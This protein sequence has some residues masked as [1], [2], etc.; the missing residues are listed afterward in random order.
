MYNKHLAM[1]TYTLLAGLLLA[2]RGS[3]AIVQ[4]RA[5]SNHGWQ[6]RSLAPRDGT[7]KLHI[8]LR[9]EDDG[10]AI[11]RQ[12][13]LA[14]DPNSP[15]F[16]QHISANQAVQLSKPATESVRNVEAWLGEH[17]LLKEASLLGGIFEID[18]SLQLAEKLLNTT[19]FT[20]SDGVH[21][22]NRAEQCSL[23]ESVAR[24]LD[25]V[26][27]TTSFPQAVYA[28]HAEHVLRLAKESERLSER[29]VSSN[30]DCNG[31]D[32]LAT[33]TCIR[34]TYDTNFDGLNYTA[35][36]NR[37]SFA[38]YATEGASFNPR[39]LQQ[40]MQKYNPP[41]AQANAS[42]RVVGPGDP[43][44]SNGIGPKFETS[45]TTSAFLGLAY[46]E[47]Q[48]AILYNYGGVF[49]PK[50]GAT[51]D[52]FVMFLQQLISNETVPSVI[53]ISESA[54]ENLLDPDYARR[55]CNMMAQVGARGVSLLFSAGN[56]GPNG[57]D[58][59]GEHK[60]IFEPKFP[61]SCPWVT[62]VG[63]TTNLADEEAAT[64]QTI[65]LVSQLGFTSTGGGFS[66]V[67]ARPSYQSQQVQS[68]INKHI[69]ESYQTASGFNS[70]GRGYPDISA[71]ST[72]FPTFVDGFEVPTGG[73][74]A[75]TPTWGAVIALL[76][77]YEA[78]HGRPSLGFLNPWLYSLDGTA[79]KD[80]V[81][82]GNNAGECLGLTGGCKIGQ[83]LGF[84]VT[85]GW[86]PATGLGSPK[87]R[88]LVKISEAGRLAKRSCLASLAVALV[89][90][91]I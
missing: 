46:P 61:A 58:P 25:F 27:P 22:I 68:Y 51:Y 47:V 41:A 75:A 37:T 52:N 57:Q 53:S 17:G 54:D 33:P 88:D 23:P 9:Q 11:E 35:Q 65:P 89:L 32:Q 12:L 64:K 49:G 15:G 20:F 63:G 69:P 90:V 86:D 70:S 78:F 4:K 91:S 43:A 81:K 28:E 1:Y 40:Y 67:F 50:T 55:L 6:K 87:F 44:S 5:P 24:H 2:L 72:Q 59:S 45:L 60:A 38:V 31:S 42:Y 62:A 84:D 39:D 18:T 76:N 10:A 73:T 56:N 82:G 29:Q 74:S 26:T 7:I 19:Y 66:N 3:C 71:F 36:P 8:A 21:T 85:E 48:N 14:S 77:D 30:G 79:L 80:I 83:A 34:K 16:R 13:V